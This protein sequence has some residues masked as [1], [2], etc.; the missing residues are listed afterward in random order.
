MKKILSL[1]FICGLLLQTSLAQT[2]PFTHLTADSA[3]IG[4]ANGSS[5]TSIFGKIYL[6]NISTDIS[7]DTFVVLKNGLVLKIPKS[8]LGGDF[9]T[10]ATPQ[11]VT[12]L[13]T[14]GNT[15]NFSGGN[16]VL[17]ATSD[18]W[19][20][21]NNASSSRRTG[22]MISNGIN[23]DIKFSMGGNQVLGAVTEGPNVLVIGTGYQGG[24]GG[25]EKILLHSTGKG[26]IWLF[27]ANAT[28]NTS[29]WPLIVNGSITGT[30][31]IRSGGVSGQFLKAD[32]SVDAT[33]YYKLNDGPQFSNGTFTNG[34]IVNLPSGV[35]GKALT[36]ARSAGSYAY[37]LGLDA[38]LSNFNIYDNNGTTPIFTIVQATKRWRNPSLAGGGDRLVMVDNNGDN[39]G[40]GIGS[41][42]SISGGNLVGTGGSS[43]TVAGSGTAGYFPKWT[44]SSAQGNSILYESGSSVITNGYVGAN[45]AFYGPTVSTYWIPIAQGWETQS[46]SSTISR[47]TF[48]TSDG[49]VRGGVGANASGV[50]GGFLNTSGTFVAYADGSG[51]FTISGNMSG[52]SATFSGDVT[53]YSDRRL[54][55]DIRQ[56]SSVSD[57]LRLILSADYREIE[58]GKQNKG[59]IAQDIE[60]YFPE[61]VMTDSLGLKSINYSKMTVPLLKG[62]QEHDQQL[63]D[64]KR[65][66]QAMAYTLAAVMI[67]LGLTLF[68]LYKK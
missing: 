56:M 13:K 2:P 8:Q 26:N 20:R 46:G 28:L 40:L 53:A 34:L 57:S 43:G 65:Q 27:D 47:N 29:Y 52:T 25:S 38:G 12:A 10:I 44:G 9:V 19:F 45:T 30:S 49:I 55:K 42:L 60:K 50:V 48:K 4:K 24:G 18:Q 31:F 7:I 37:H 14:F 1:I 54:K 66:M 35:S 68:K 67:L 58:S 21:A 36:I 3:R 16:V 23:T 64:L 59:F 15:V 6:K 32:G 62:W 5:S 63:V 22:F 51:N 61:F 17:T 41:G 39:I 33:S 11:T